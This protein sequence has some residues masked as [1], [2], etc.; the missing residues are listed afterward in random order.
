MKFHSLIWSMNFYFRLPRSPSLQA[1]QAITY[2][3][4]LWS[5]LCM[6]KHWVCQKITMTL[7][8][9]DQHNC[10]GS[11]S[12]LTRV[13]LPHHDTP[14]RDV[15]S[16]LMHKGIFHTAEIKTKINRIQKNKF[17][18]RRNVSQDYP[19]S[20][21]GI[22]LCSQKELSLKVRCQFVG[23]ISSVVV[24]VVH[25]ISWQLASDRGLQ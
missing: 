19:V 24:E 7:W 20:K 18:I 25:N 11:R 22:L 10:Q 14:Q 1:A 3:I 8:T 23:L 6:L 16:Q 17:L 15:Q 9:D 21:V 13:S 4:F 2:L 12:S 5:V